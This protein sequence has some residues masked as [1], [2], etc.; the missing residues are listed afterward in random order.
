M[1]AGGTAGSSAGLG[2]TSGSAGSEEAGSAGTTD[3]AGSAGASGSAGT[4]GAAGSGGSSGSAGADGSAG[5][6]DAGS[7]GSAGPSSTL[8][9]FSFFVTSQDAMRSLSG[10][11]QGFG[12]DLRFGETGSGAGLRGADKICSAIA[13][14]SMPGAGAKG[15]RA[16]L[17][18]TS[19]GR[20][21]GGRID[22]I[23]RVGNGPWYDRLGRLVAANP[24]ALLNPRP[25]GADPAISDDLP[26]ENG[27]PNRCAT[28]KCLDNHD[29]LTGF[30]ARER[31]L[32][33]R[34]TCQDWTSALPESGGPI[35]GHSWASEAIPS[36][37]QAHR[38]L[39]CAPGGTL[40]EEL[41]SE[42]TVGS[43]GGYGGIYCFAL[44]P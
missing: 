24:E 9:K 29:T 7:G 26:D 33:L 15:W 32:T 23:D 21:G 42:P 1:S 31:A 43:G 35:V 18:A 44:V 37:L 25:G 27:A 5:C 11:D 3:A 16:F 6:V 19:D 30:V 20:C 34:D 28:G 13:E 8:D 38:N 17:S 39:G 10:N 41:P 4:S 14:K 36:W 22:A 12:G 40:L 2:G